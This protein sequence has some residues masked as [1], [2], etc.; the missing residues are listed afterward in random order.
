LSSNNGTAQARFLL[1]NTL[2]LAGVVFYS[3][4]IPFELDPS[5][6][7]LVATGTNALAMTVGSF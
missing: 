3:Q 1:P 7:I 4:M 5:F 2:S 6:N